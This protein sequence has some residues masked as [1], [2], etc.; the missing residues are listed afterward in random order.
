M[1]QTEQG[2]KDE[3]YLPDN[4]KNCH[5]ELSAAQQ[6]LEEMK[7]KY[8][9]AAAQV[10]GAGHLRPVKPPDVPPI[11]KAVVEKRRAAV[12]NKRAECAA[13]ER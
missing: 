5:A 10:D 7:D 9:R 11:R 2:E 1:A 3:L 4:L 8:L 13:G 6:E 12:G